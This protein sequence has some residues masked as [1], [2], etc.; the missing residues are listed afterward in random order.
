[1][2]SDKTSINWYPGHMKKT[3]DMFSEE[4]KQVDVV[5][6]I[7]DARIPLS[8]RNPEISKIVGNKT[9]I[10]L[11]NKV[12]LVDKNKLDI[13]KKYFLK[14]NTA[15]YIIPI[16]AEKGMNIKDIK[17]KIKELYNKKLE[18]VAKKRFKKN[19]NPFYYSRHTKCR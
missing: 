7:L 9:R 18:K 14:T 16:S 17:S 4:I 3:M 11:L 8:S 13:W 15:D 1:M 2:N 10:V 12:D 19:T 6:E 5:L